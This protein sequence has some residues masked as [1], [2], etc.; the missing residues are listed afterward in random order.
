MG[1]F[2]RLKREK[3]PVERK[4]AG[5]ILTDVSFLPGGSQWQGEIVGGN[6]LFIVPIMGEKGFRRRVAEKMEPGPPRSIAGMVSVELRKNGGHS[7]PGI[8]I[9]DVIRGLT[10]DGVIVSIQ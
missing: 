3:D 4:Q 1:I 6:P 8:L 10:P 7:I 2:S 9:K 5:R